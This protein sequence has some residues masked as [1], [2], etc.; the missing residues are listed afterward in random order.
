MRYFEL[1]KKKLN[2]IVTPEEL[3][4]LLKDFHHV[5][6]SRGVPK[7]YTE[8]DPEE[9]FSAYGKLYSKLKNGEKITEADEGVHISVGIT[10]HLEN[11][12]YKPTQKLSVPDF[13]EPCPCI[14]A[15]CIVPFGEKLSTT[16]FV[17]Q[18]PENVCGLRLIFPTKIQYDTSKSVCDEELD[19]FE[20]YEALVSRIKS[21]TKPLNVCLGGKQHRTSVRISAKAKEG[22]KNSYFITTNKI[23]IL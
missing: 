14:E 15:F 10:R 18:F 13:S 22:F 16:F 2:F 19:D 1:A 9:L 17:G 5:E 7:N 21:I 12:L 20:T 23:S 6:I 3:L 11:C 8:S 4:D